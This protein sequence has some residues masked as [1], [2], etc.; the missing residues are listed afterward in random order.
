MNPSGQTPPAVAI[1]VLNWNGKEDT[2]EC[3][4]S[5]QKL[6]YPNYRTVVVDNGSSDDSVTAI[7][8]LFPKSMVIENGSN[9]GYAGGNNVGIKWALD[10]AFDYILLLNND[11]FVAT[12]LIDI[13]VSAATARADAFIYGAKIFFAD[14]PNI[15]WFAGGRWV[16]KNLAF[17]HLGYGKPDSTEYSVVREVDYIT[18]CALFASASSFEIVGLLDDNFFLTFEETDWCYR[19]R[20]E[21][22]RCV[23]IPEAVLWHKVSSSF[24]GSTSPLATYFMFRNKLLWARSHCSPSE[25]KS[26]RNQAWKTAR[27]ILLP[28]LTV[29]NMNVG[30]VKSIL[31]AVSSWRRRA[32]ALRR[33]PVNIAILCGFR[34]YVLGRFG[35]CPRWIR[36]LNSRA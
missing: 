8:S 32:S 31:W 33:D 16:S 23:V 30:L 18:G 3:L 22:F 21:G 14:R 15:L 24:G 10:H 6:S 1:I 35:D 27:N 11:T 29:P 25:Y 28:P 26:I 20:K 19:A 36:D 2:L 17:T 13:F 34:D 12:N 9:A 5:L 4:Q 7:R